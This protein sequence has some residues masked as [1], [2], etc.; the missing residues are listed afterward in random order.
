MQKEIRKVT[1]FAKLAALNAVSAWADTD[2]G[3]LSVQASLSGSATAVTVQLEFSNDGVE[4]VAGATYSLSQ[5]TKSDGTTFT[6]PG[7]N[8]AFVRLRISAMTGTGVITG[9]MRYREQN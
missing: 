8:F 1:G 7:N 9:T 2:G 6:S 4:A 3:L 5:T